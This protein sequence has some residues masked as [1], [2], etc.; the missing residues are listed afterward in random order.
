MTI[1]L[2]A[3]AT[4]I[5]VLITLNRLVGIDTMIRFRAVID[6]LTTVALAVLFMGTITGMLIGIGAGLMVTLFLAL[7]KLVRDH[8]E[9][10]KTNEARYWKSAKAAAH[11][12]R[13]PRCFTE[14]TATYAQAHGLAK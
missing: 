14:G 1:I 5:A 11:K 8:Q 7:A 12:V 10:R 2:A 4:T 6:V 9:L 3:L 13:L